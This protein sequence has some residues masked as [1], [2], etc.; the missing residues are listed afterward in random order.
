MFGPIVS[1]FFFAWM[2]C[3][4]DKTEENSEKAGKI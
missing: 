3:F 4:R 1:H 2:G